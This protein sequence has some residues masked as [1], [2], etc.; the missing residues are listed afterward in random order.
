MLIATHL[1]SFV[2]WSRIRLKL[3]FLVVSSMRT[4]LPQSLVIASVWTVLTSFALAQPNDALPKRERQEPARPI[5]LTQG[6][7]GQISS[8][9]FSPDSRFLYVA[10]ADKVI[11][12]W[13]FVEVRPNE[14][15]PVVA[16]TMRWEIARGDWGELNAIAVS[17]AKEEN[18]IAAAGKDPRFTGDI[19]LWNTGTGRFAIPTEPSVLPLKV[20]TVNPPNGHTRTVSSLAFSPSGR[21][22]ASVDNNGAIWFWDIGTGKGTE[23]HKG[24][25]GD[26]DDLGFI[27][28][29]VFLAENYFAALVPGDLSRPEAFPHQLG[30]F[31]VGDFSRPRLIKKEK[32]TALSK[33]TGEE[34]WASAD[35][36][37]DIQTW[38]GIAPIKPLAEM[39]N[40][41]TK[42]KTFQVVPSVVSM[43]FFQADYLAAI[44]KRGLSNGNV[45]TPAR[46][47]I[48][49][50]K[51]RQLIDFIEIG[52]HDESRCVAVSPD[53]KWLA[54][55][56]PDSDEVRMIRLAEVVNG[57]LPPVNNFLRLLGR[58][59][60][61]WKAEFVDS[62]EADP[63]LKLRF[64]DRSNEAGD[65]EIKPEDYRGFDLEQMQIVPL[66]GQETI[67]T[68]DSDQGSWTAEIKMEKDDKGNFKEG[69]FV[70][71]FFNRQSRA[72]I[73]PHWKN[74]GPVKSYCWIARANEDQP[75]AIALGTERQDGIYVYS[76]PEANQKP[77]LLRYYRDHVGAVTSLSV[78]PNRRLLVSSS[79]DQTI[80]FWSLDELSPI[81]GRF[82]NRTAWGA[83]FVIENG[84]LIARNVNEKG[85]AFRRGIKNGVQL[86]KLEW[87]ND[88]KLFNA[89]TPDEMLKI[90]NEREIFKEFQVFVLNGP[91]LGRPVVPGWEPLATLFADRHDEW[92]LFTPE[93]VFEASAA[94]GPKLLGWQ[95]NQGRGYD[96]EIFEA[97]ELQN[98]RKPAVLKS[99]LTAGV[100]IPANLN[101]AA[102]ATDRPIVQ[103][104]SPKLTDPPATAD[105]PVQFKAVIKYPKKVNLAAIS[106][107]F[108]VNSHRVLKIL[109]DATPTLQSTTHPD[110]VEQEVTIPVNPGEQL[111]SY[112]VSTTTTSEPEKQHRTATVFSHAAK[113][114]NKK[115]FRLHVVS[116]SCQNYP[117]NALKP[118]KQPKADAD[119]LV[120][121]LT[122]R[123]GNYYAMPN[124]PWVLDD[125]NNNRVN[126]E[127]IQKK[128]AEVKVSLKES[129]SDDLLI[130]YLA[131]HGDVYDDK[132][133]FIPSSPE[134]I[135]ARND[136]EKVEACVTW[137]DLDPLCDLGCRKIFIIDTCRGGKIEETAK[138]AFDSARVRATLLVSSSSKDQEAKEANELP[139]SYFMAY[140]LNGFGGEADGFAFN[141]RKPPADPG[142]KLK[143]EDGVV[144]FDEVI[145]YVGEKVWDITDKTQR[146]CVFERNK[147][148]QMQ[149]DLCPVTLN[150]AKP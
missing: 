122:L 28:P 149:F 16:Q 6:A 57:K 75:F 89:V 66:T 50:W 9:A 147:S 110:Y 102:E 51:T 120:D 105:Q 58:G 41:L 13:S 111:S 143:K 21:K 81:A 33:K 144:Q 49:N 2:V 11:R 42:M 127:A 60:A 59:K 148:F 74:Q 86:E 91:A 71:L 117:A 116:I 123:A 76:L 150:S 27:A 132:Y 142:M 24:A 82:K 63:K 54:Y 10:G 135:K 114:R 48:W 97:G 108:Y 3:F 141:I 72:R 64:L 37:G 4:V 145:C 98:L 19:G 22:L 133:C 68:S 40:P 8:L 85:I 35:S 53:G 44:R 138:A 32:I 118:L 95:Y 112:G 1:L 99:L 43:S 65:E 131:G 126:R 146:P 47:E 34:I 101:V 38:S 121:E 83:D 88:K 5:L 128:I 7:I 90:L 26:E 134:F 52:R 103:I 55:G 109:G 92:V 136:K 124:K 31:N 139:N 79:M 17:P 140:W 61:I 45:E 70:E 129:N 96:P 93:G 100:A 39:I 119:A 30:I 130:I 84:K 15:S 137:K 78:S 113:N 77:Q 106:H 20:R 18:L 29:V 115:L 14:F 67:R 87:V 107:S 80:K 125:M 25:K 12:T 23:V 46:L 62:G 73:T 36:Q 56:C 94:E 104:I 69:N